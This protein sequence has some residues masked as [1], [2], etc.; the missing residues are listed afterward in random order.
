MSVAVSSSS[1]RIVVVGAANMDL[2]GTPFA[3]LRPG[4]SNP[5]RI[6]LSPGGVGRNIAENLVRLGCDVSLLTL[7][8]D[9]LYGSMI[10]SSCIATG[11]DMSLALTDSEAA[12]SAYLCINGPEGDLHV[13]V[14]DMA[15][16]DRM[17]PSLLK[18][19]LPEL[20]RVDLV[21]LDA[22]LPETT[23]I[24]LS[25]HLTVPLAADP[26]SAAKAPRLK[27]C[28]SRLTLMK[29][30]L[31]EAQVLTGISIETDGD[32]IRAAEAL[33]D[34][35]M[36]RVFLSLSANGVLACDRNG[37]LRLPCFPAPVR[38]TTGCGDAFLSA[39]CVA[40]LRG[41]TLRDAARWGLAAAA[42]CAQDPM[43]V[44][45]SLSAEAIEAFLSAQHSS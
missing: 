25:A 20:N 30:N 2:S 42:L 36:D 31:A 21:V 28:L 7:L 41:M 11:I 14:S 17:L 3:R 18:P 35:G 29:P 23:L 10:R 32:V 16:A 1:P 39:A 12:T 6:R 34:A 43:A 8:G 19:L 5:G 22:N 38:N 9:D 33:L 13:A 40:V 44:C 15:I 37:C 27:Q 4:D 45:T 26:V 24:W